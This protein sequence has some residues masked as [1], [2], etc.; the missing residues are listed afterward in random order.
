M[1]LAIPR[2]IV[3]GFGLVVAILAGNALVAVQTV[4]TLTEA[5]QA[6]TDGVR[7]RDLL[8]EVRGIVSSS[9]TAQRN[10]ILTGNKEYLEHSLKSLKSTESLSNEILG[11]VDSDSVEAEKTGRLESLIAARAAL[12]ESALEHLQKGR[13]VAALQTMTMK[14][15]RDNL[16]SIDELFDQFGASQGALFARRTDELKTSSLFSLVTFYVATFCGLALLGLLCYFV[17]R[18]I[19]ERRR[20]EEKLRVVATHDPLTALPNRTLL[21]ERLSHALAKAQ[22]HGRQLAVL[23]V[24]LDRFKNVNDTLGHDAGDRLLQVASQRLY[25]CL[26]ETDTMARQGGDEF[27]VL[28]D[29]LTDREPVTHVAQRILDAVGEPFVIEGQEIHLTASIGISVYPEDGRTLLKNADIAMYRAKDKGKN[30]YQFYSAQMDNY[31]VERLS[32]ES[33]LRRAL[34]REEFVLHYQPKVNIASGLI[35]GVEAL[36]RWQHPELGWVAP[37]RF[38]PIAEENG[39]ILPI[40]AWVL[41]TAC[42]QSRAWQRQGVRRFPVAVNLSPRQFAGETLLDDVK[43]ALDVSG[44]APADLELEITEGMVMNNPERAVNLLQQLKG[45]GIRV[46]IDDFGTGYSSLAYLKRFPID[47]VKVDRSFVE[48][49]PDDVDSMAIAQAVIAM[50]HS[51]RLNVVAEGVESEAQLGFLHGEGCDEI[52]GYYFCEAR[53][54]SEISA[55]MRTTLR[56]G[57]TIYLSE[58]R[59]KA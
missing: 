21:H 4:V 13:K 43:A 58:R 41:K 53:P 35:T 12:F 46:A 7:V 18:D 39:L 9:E 45:L 40:G 55:I 48:D 19:A 25:D 16:N 37:G 59:R 36:L 10:Y 34:E 27:V 29:E 38:I 42:I 26:R 20:A 51:L 1:S 30:N 50:A 11:L 24:D 14:A 23:F 44:L 56:R 57:N 17:Y 3:I 28:M 54:A 2:K 8:K 47:S 31:S 22:R 6:V 32:L 5:T 33:G 15:G 49:I 52:Q